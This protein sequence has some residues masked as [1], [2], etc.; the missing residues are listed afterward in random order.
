MSSQYT[1][2]NHISNIYN[3][4]I[5]HILD[6]HVVRSSSSKFITTYNHHTLQVFHIY[7]KNKHIAQNYG[8]SAKY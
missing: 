6:Y 1:A 7:K 2:Y 5:F 4:Y 8:L 3:T